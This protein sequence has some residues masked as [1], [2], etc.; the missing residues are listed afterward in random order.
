MKRAI[1]FVLCA[2]VLASMALSAAA[3]ALS[4]TAITTN[5]T[6]TTVSGAADPET[7]IETDISKVSAAAAEATT[8]VAE[9]IA[10]AVSDKV[11]AIA[12]TETAAAATEETVAATTEA[13]AEYFGVSAEELKETVGA[14]ESGEGVTVVA[15]APVV[16]VGFDEQAT[17]VTVIVTTSAATGYTEGE[18][19]TVMIG[20]P[21][22]S[23]NMK[24][25]AVTGVAGKDGQVVLTYS[26]ELVQEL[27]G[28]DAVMAFLGKSKAGHTTTK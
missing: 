7:Y 17:S 12:G 20:I 21:D 22:A 24:W 14:T 16:A 28:K 27:D 5:T 25:V 11:A 4:P 1:S 26:A 10:T 19:V 6:E 23:G 13:V 18:K 2:A 15:V 8:T 9:E 3:A